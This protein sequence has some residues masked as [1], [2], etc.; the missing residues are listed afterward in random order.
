M[1]P[2]RFGTRFLPHSIKHAPE[3]TSFHQLIWHNSYSFSHPLIDTPGMSV[4]R[5]VLEP[6]GERALG[7]D[8]SEEEEDLFELGCHGRSKLTWTQL[9]FKM[10]IIIEGRPII[11]QCIHFFFLV[12]KKA[13]ICHPLCACL[14]SLSFDFFWR[15]SFSWSYKLTNKILPC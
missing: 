11:L 6:I 15:W 9:G 13:Q 2:F 14:L 10:R 1:L 7:W 8:E 5:K 3:Y 4:V 12:S